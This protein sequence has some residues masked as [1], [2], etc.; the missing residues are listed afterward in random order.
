MVS[1][2]DWERTLIEGAVPLCGS[3]KRSGFVHLSSWDDVLRTADLYF[4]PDESP[5]ALCVEPGALHE[6][7]KWESVESRGGASFPHLYGRRIPL[8]A[9]TALHRLEINEVGTFQLGQKE[10]RGDRARVGRLELFVG[11]ITGLHVGAV[12]NAANAQLSGGGGVDGA[13]HR[14][15]GEEQL[16]RACR[17]I[18]GCPTGELRVTPGF[19]L[20]APYIF[21]AVGPIWRGG[22]E[23]EDRLLASC[24]RSVIRAAAEH[25]LASLAIPAISC[26]VYGFP[27]QRAVDI[28][29]QGLR[30]EIPRHAGIE[31]VVLCCF[32]GPITELYRERL[33]SLALD[34][35]EL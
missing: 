10:V 7:L 23:N 5:L 32:G 21:H 19:S 31:R 25:S 26:G 29:L 22:H 14:A 8:G 28:A 1:Q 15:A 33:K 24:Y 30:E 35:A 4:E 16:Q 17:A 12:V 2:D 27:H 11:D 34:E 18:G 9:V 20:P 3:D 6:A 13:I